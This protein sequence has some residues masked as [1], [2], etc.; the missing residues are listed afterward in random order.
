ME[1][2]GKGKQYE[3]LKV[4]IWFHGHIYRKNKNTGLQKIKRKMLKVEVVPELR[5][6]P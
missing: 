5:L 6:P 2:L 4:S 3:R 1:S